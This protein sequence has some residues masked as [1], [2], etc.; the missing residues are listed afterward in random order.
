ML[1]PL[2]TMIVSVVEYC[3]VKDDEDGK[4]ENGDEDDDVD[5]DDCIGGGGGADW[6]KVMLQ[7]APLILGG[8]LLPPTIL[9]FDP[10]WIAYHTLVPYHAYHTIVGCPVC[11]R[12]QPAHS[13]TL[14]PRTLNVTNT[15]TN[16]NTNT[17]VDANVICLYMMATN[18]K[19]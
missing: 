14:T 13:P 1:V 6:L 3:G 5:H 8:L 7:A 9:Y 17:Q 12:H 16:T 11:Y 15:N 2:E 18:T 4:D 19:L 10:W